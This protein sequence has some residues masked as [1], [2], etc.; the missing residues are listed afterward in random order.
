MC[1]CGCYDTFRTSVA[2][3]AELPRRATNFAHNSNRD[4]PQPH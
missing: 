4:T 3:G 1:V 2:K